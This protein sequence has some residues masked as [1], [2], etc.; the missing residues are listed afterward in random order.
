VND[1]A[2]L[3]N[4]TVGPADA[5]LLLGITNAPANVNPV[6]SGSVTVSNVWIQTDTRP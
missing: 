5:I 3:P 1:W 4:Y 6:P 2:V